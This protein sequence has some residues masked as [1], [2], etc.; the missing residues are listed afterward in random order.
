[1]IAT[2]D[3]F[4]RRLVQLDPERF[5]FVLRADE[6]IAALS[7]E[8]APQVYAAIL[9]FF[10]A[11]P[12]ARCGAPGTLVHHIE[13]YYP[14]YV[15]TLRESVTRAP[16]YNGVLM[17][18]RILNSSISEADRH[19]YVSILRSVALGDSAP[20]TIQNLAIGFLNRQTTR[21]QTPPL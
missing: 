15:A 20:E 2:V 14:N 4:E 19:E 10:E 13:N 3:E 16:S 8:I 21:S 17:I 11:H 5:D 9:R 18:N 12:E 6:L 7:P 1:M